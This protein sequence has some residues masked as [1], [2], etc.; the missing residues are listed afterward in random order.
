ML[1][2]I[3]GPG[4]GEGKWNACSVVLTKGPPLP[5]HSL[6]VGCVKEMFFH[7]VDKTAGWQVQ[8]GLLLGLTVCYT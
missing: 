7:Q 6:S 1:Y 2:F 3:F 8:K 5:I 4:K